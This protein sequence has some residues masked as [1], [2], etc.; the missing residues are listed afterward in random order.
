ML[1]ESPC[2]IHLW[3]VP[4]L[5]SPGIFLNRGIDQGRGGGGGHQGRI[6]LGEILQGEFSA[7]P[8][9]RIWYKRLEVFSEKK[10]CI[11]KMAVP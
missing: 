3:W 1:G 4:Q 6:W 5:I 10:K 2:G 9:K 8:L 11:P 7:P